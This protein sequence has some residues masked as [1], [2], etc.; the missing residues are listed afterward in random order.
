MRPVSECHVLQWNGQTDATIEIPALAYA[1]YA[2]PVI[3][4]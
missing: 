3:S 1:A 2:T 4:R